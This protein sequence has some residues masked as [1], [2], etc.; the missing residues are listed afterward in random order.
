MDVL[1]V[2]TLAGLQDGDTAALV[3][4]P[5]CHRM[6]EMIAIVLDQGVHHDLLAFRSWREI[7]VARVVSESDLEL[8]DSGLSRI[9]PA[10]QQIVSCL[11]RLK[12]MRA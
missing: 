9:C 10:Q 3:L 2:S 7:S 8:F 11:S 4:L 1:Y 12:P 6:N 5:R